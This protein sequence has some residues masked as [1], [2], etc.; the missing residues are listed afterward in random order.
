MFRLRSC[1]PVL[2][3][4]ILSIIPGVVSASTIT[5]AGQSFT[6]TISLPD[7]ITAFH[8]GSTESVSNG[9]TVDTTVDY[10]GSW[11][12]IT[13][14]AQNFSSQALTFTLN[15][16]LPLDPG[17]YDAAHSS[18]TGNGTSSRNPFLVSVV[19][20]AANV[21]VLDAGDPM[22]NLGIDVGNGCT[23]PSGKP[24]FLCTTS[25]AGATFAP[26]SYSTLYGALAFSMGG[27]NSDPFHANHLDWDVYF[28]VDSVPEPASLPLIGGGLLALVLRRKRA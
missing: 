11:G 17:M 3:L 12:T 16:T 25:S 15:L 4:A 20:P 24:S 27:S 23:V 14:D 21:L 13:F 26:Q 1:G 18:M 10:Y 9:Y 19:S 5:I 7:A 6:D 8:L 22:A 2:A 28:E